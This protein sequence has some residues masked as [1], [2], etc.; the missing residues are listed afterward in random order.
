MQINSSNLEIFNTKD[1]DTFINFDDLPLG[2]FPKY[3]FM[4]SVSFSKRD[5]LI[6]DTIGLIAFYIKNAKTLSEMRTI[7]NN[8]ISFFIN[9]VG[10]EIEESLTLSELLLRFC[11]Y[12]INVH[13]IKKMI[14]NSDI[15][16]T[17]CTALFDQAHLLVYGQRIPE[18]MPTLYIDILKNF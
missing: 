9:R 5:Q 12:G 2:L 15:V 10:L 7:L 17:F 16:C 13:G 3:N 14:P 4:L 6:S 8:F 18:V 11:A 1:L